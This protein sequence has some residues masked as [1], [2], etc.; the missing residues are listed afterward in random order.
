MGNGLLFPGT[1]SR[2]QSFR[3]AAKK[4]LK[5]IVGLVPIFILAGFLEGFVTRMTGMPGIFKIAIILGSFIFIFIYFIFI[6][7]KIKIDGI[8]TKDHFLQKEKLQS[9]D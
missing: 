8:H 7:F 3:F 9:E 1:Y 5:I 2:V 4:G 6:P